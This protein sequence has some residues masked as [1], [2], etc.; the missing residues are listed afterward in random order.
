MRPAG[1]VT[2]RV[3]N[4]MYD[5]PRLLLQPHANTHARTH[6]R[7]HAHTHTHTL[8]LFLSLSLSLSLAHAHTH[9]RTHAWIVAARV[10]KEL[11]AAQAR[12]E[13]GGAGSADVGSELEQELAMQVV[14]RVCEHVIGLGFRV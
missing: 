4:C 8:S 10:Q 12:L 1:V 7:T 11:E 14:V 6:A 13:W 9:A 3:H 2:L 5:T